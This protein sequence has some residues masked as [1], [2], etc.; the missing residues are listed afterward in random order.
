MPVSG[1]LLLTLQT[2]FWPVAV[3]KDKDMSLQRAETQEW[4]FQGVV[5]KVEFGPGVSPRS[6]L[7][8]MYS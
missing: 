5:V 6:S 1:A 4:S 3:S 2:T 8:L 7:S